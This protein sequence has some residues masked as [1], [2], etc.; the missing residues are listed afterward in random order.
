MK[1]LVEIRQK[2]DSIDREIAKLFEERMAAAADVAEYKSKHNLPILDRER[3]KAVIEENS[4][5]ISDDDI[6]SYYILFQKQMMAISRSYQRELVSGKR[7]EKACSKEP[8]TT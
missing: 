3:E 7:K 5:Y 8:K 6:R 4:K 1:D 2:I